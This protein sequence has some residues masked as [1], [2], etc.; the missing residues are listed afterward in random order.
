MYN[1]D[2][3]LRYLNEKQKV[4]L[5]SK[6]LELQFEHISIYEEL[7]NKDASQ[8]TSSEIISYYKLRA[9]T[10]VDSVMT[11]NSQLSLYTQWCISQTLVKDN[12]NHYLEIT[13][14]LART[15]L[16]NTLI[17]SRILT[18]QQLSEGLNKLVNPID[19]FIILALFEGIRGEKYQDITLANINQIKGNT[20]KLISGRTVNISNELKNYAMEANDTY[21]YY[22]LRGDRE[23]ALH[24]DNIF[25]HKD[26]SRSNDLDT[27]AQAIKRKIINI[28]RD[29]LNVDD[30]ITI[31]GNDIILSGKIHYMKEAAKTY[32]CPVNMLHHKKEFVQDYFN[33]FGMKRVYWNNFFEQYRKYLVQ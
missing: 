32:D 22:T 9:F 19:K 18:R 1:K 2:V 27:M 31:R 12:Q 29:A 30:N 13:S 14:E 23:L 20:I 11:L 17:D 26:S 28:C 15:L 25:K 24:G 21:V 4:S 16:N 5:P 10:N 6:Y 8:F 7:L 33:Q 3:K